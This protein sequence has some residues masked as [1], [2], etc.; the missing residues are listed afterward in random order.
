MRSGLGA[1]DH[2]W[3]RHITKTLP[4]PNLAQMIDA[5]QESSSGKLNLRATGSAMP[6]TDDREVAAADRQRPSADARGC[7]TASR[8]RW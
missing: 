2:S 3:Y 8:R 4:W 7:V 5:Y 1:A 6:A